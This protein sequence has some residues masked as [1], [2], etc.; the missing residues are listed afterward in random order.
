L[1]FVPDL[2]EDEEFQFQVEVRNY[3]QTKLDRLWFS[4]D[5]GDQYA[6]GTNLNI[7]EAWG[8]TETSHYYTRAGT[9][10][11]AVTVTDEED[12]EH[13]TG[14]KVDVRNA[15]PVPEITIIRQSTFED[16]VVTFDPESTWDTPSDL[17]SLTYSWTLPGEPPTDF[18][19]GE[20]AKFERT[21]NKAGT[22]PITLRVM[23]DDGAIATLVETFTVDNQP[24]LAVA[25]K[26][27]E[28][29]E[30]IPVLFSGTN[31][32][33]STSD[34]DALSFMWDF[35]DGTTATGAEVEHSYGDSGTYTAYLKVVDDDGAMTV[36]PIEVIVN[37]HAPR[38]VITVHQEEGGSFVMLDGSMSTDSASDMKALT[39]YWVL[40]SGTTRIG[41]EVTYRFRSAG[42]HE[43]S[44]KVVDPEG[45]SD[46]AWANIT[47]TNMAPV[48]KVSAI[49][50]VHEDDPIRFDGRSS[51]D[52][53]GEIISYRWDFGDG[54]VAEGQQVTH[55]YS[56]HGE[57][58][59][60]LTLKDDLGSEAWADREITVVNM[61]PEI[62]LTGD[63]VGT[64]GKDMLFDASQTQDTASDLPSLDFRWDYGDGTIGH[65]KTVL[66]A[67]EK[68]GDYDVVLTVTDDDGT[69][70]EEVHRVTVMLEDIML[71]AG[72]SVLKLDYVIIDTL[73]GEAGLKSE[74]TF[75]VQGTVSLVT[76]IEGFEDLG[77]LEGQTIDVMALVLE[78]GQQ[79]WTE[80]DEDGEFSVGLEAPKKAGKF[81]ILMVA[82]LRP[83]KAEV[84]AQA[85]VQKTDDAGGV[86]VDP[87]IAG[88]TTVTI[89]LVALG[90]I[91]GTDIGRYKFFTLMIPLF[92]RI[93]KPKVLDHFERGRIFE[94]IRKNP[95]DSYS[96]IRRT[97][98]LKNGA[99][100]HH[101]RVLE[102]HE[103][104]ISKRDGMYKRFYPKGMK[105]PEGTHKSIQENI[106][107]MIMSNPKISQKEI[108]ERMGIDR[109]T[110]NYHIKILL[111]MGVIR[112]EKSGRIKF[113][114]FV[115]VKDPLPYKA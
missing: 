77:K 86:I 92:T 71:L 7:I 21:Y 90:A 55:T 19:S 34:M 75:R 17:S 89:S 9:Y 42:E 12:K 102:R 100:A 40:T 101:L 83:L 24:P 29:F 56:F 99:L 35:G 105:I 81:T 70:R 6:D 48:A 26:D 14:A 25:G 112:S 37:N 13:V 1:N 93:R 65:G 104:I 41:K 31:S 91:G 53:D 45:A 50:V 115:G 20:D 8:L 46:M 106:L 43:V 108:A 51:Y 66:H 11:L 85:F 80:A 97:L 67:F 69:Y 98:G 33:D 60:R 28:V 110:V 10:D 82:T 111:A 87:M 58:T 49:S 18:L 59:A 47:V 36:D 22:Y 73:D 78:T 4:W 5:F 72:E 68:A 16:E 38:A 74:E 96:S 64:V 3:D 88:T 52:T 15:L 95:G 30:D 109:S 57:Y 76:D 54:T 2:E 79:A 63:R 62:K 114:Y 113:Y 32:L 103:Y 39:Y 27:V 23:D 84:T 44:L 107:E 94:H 61:A